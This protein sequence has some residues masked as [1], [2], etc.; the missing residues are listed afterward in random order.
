[1]DDP[2]KSFILANIVNLS[3]ITAA[4]KAAIDDLTATVNSSDAVT[5]FLDDA[6]CAPLALPP[7]LQPCLQ[8]Y[9]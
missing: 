6:R 7:S 2:R 3:G 5:A 8:L 4:G 9:T 1:M